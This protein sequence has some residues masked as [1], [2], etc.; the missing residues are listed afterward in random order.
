MILPPVPGKSARLLGEREPSLLVAT[1]VSKMDD[2]GIREIASYLEKSGYPESARALKARPA[3][4]NL[5]SRLLLEAYADSSDDAFFAYFYHFNY[6][7]IG[8]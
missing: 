6:H 1:R 2:T 5:V 4:G 3:D 7:C 8:N